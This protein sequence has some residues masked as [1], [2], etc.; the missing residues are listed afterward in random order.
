MN[1]DFI[2]GNTGMKLGLRFLS[3][4]STS[5]TSSMLSRYEDPQNALGRLTI[6]D[7]MDKVY[8]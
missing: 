2:P 1:M 5:S 7:I 4:A 3:T 6:L 8:N